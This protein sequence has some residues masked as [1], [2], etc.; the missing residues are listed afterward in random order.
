MK[1]LLFPILFGMFLASCG[2]NGG[3][4]PIT[5]AA[6]KKASIKIEANQFMT[7]SLQEGV[8]ELNKAIEFTVSALNEEYNVTSVKMNDVELPPANNTNNY[9]FTPTEEK[10]Y[11]L[12]VTTVENE[13]IIIFTFDKLTP[14]K[15]VEE[16]TKK[17]VR[18]NI[19]NQ[20]ADYDDLIKNGNLSLKN[21]QRLVFLYN[22]SK[23]GKRELLNKIVFTFVSGKEN[24]TYEPTDK[25]SYEDGVWKYSETSYDED[26]A[27]LLFLAKGDV[28]IS[29]IVITTVP[30]VPFNIKL[31]FNN[32]TEGDKVYFLNGP[33]Y[34][35]FQKKQEV[36][37]DSEFIAGQAYYLYFTWNQYHKDFFSDLLVKY[38]GEQARVFKFYPDPDSGLPPVEIVT[39]LLTPIK[40]ESKTNILDLEWVDKAVEEKDIQLDI[41]SANKYV[42]HFME[43]DPFNSLGLT[44]LLYGSTKTINLRAK[45]GYMNLKVIVD[46]VTIEKQ[47]DSN[48]YKFS[49]P[50]VKPLT[51]AFTAE[52]GDEERQGKD[53]IDIL[54]GE[55]KAKGVILCAEEDGAMYISLLASEDH[56]TAYLNT[57]SFGGKPLARQ[58]APK[59]GGEEDVYF[60]TLNSEQA[61]K[62]KSTAASER[63]ALFSNATVAELN[64]YKST[65]VFN[66][67]AY[68]IT[69][70][71]QELTEEGALEVNGKS[72]VT[73]KVTPNEFKE[74]HSIEV[75]DK[76]L[77]NTNYTLNQEDGSITYTFNANAKKYDFF[78]QTKP[79]VVT[80]A[81]D[82][83]STPGYIIKDLPKEAVEVG[84]S[85]VLTLGVT[86][87]Q[88]GLFD[89]KITVTYDGKEAQVTEVEGEFKFTI[90]PVKG[91]SSIKVIVT[92][93]PQQ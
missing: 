43:T 29:K 65:L 92:D 84:K 9:T 81:L 42:K 88:Y 67:G 79:Q 34:I 51:I 74:I 4:T 61:N 23:Y 48:D 17:G 93:N 2:G 75:N 82:G 26:R 73:V 19:D 35:D 25:D 68:K 64:S 24:L 91:V 3:D 45:N 85:I 87:T 18:L 47:E 37:A 59:E 58:V 72:S 50:R 32:L 44:D 5:P 66:K 40:E 78:I 27:D 54:T 63:A 71:G 62:Y 33:T 28:V 11:T 13:N 46:G 10:E 39:Y 49:I 57:L 70:N 55:D 53:V 90:I 6:P 14:E 12:K 20:D 80:L 22:D 56:P 15:Y 21:N 52:E 41:A 89:K 30:Y 16:L 31:R 76:R 1:A 83:T 8:Y 7:T 38:K 60:F 36:T 77:A 86:D 69:V